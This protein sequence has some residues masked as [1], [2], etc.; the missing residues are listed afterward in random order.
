MLSRP[1]NL[2]EVGNFD[3]YFPA[4]TGFSGAWGV[5]P[6]LPSGNILIGDINSGLFILGPTYKRASYL[7]G[8]VKDQD[9]QVGPFQRECGN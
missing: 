4:S 2:V 8:I 3:T 5:Y 1:N 7:E 6:F 9:S